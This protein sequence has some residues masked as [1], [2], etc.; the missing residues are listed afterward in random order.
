M[1]RASNPTGSIFLE[2]RANILEALFQLGDSKPE[3]VWE[4]PLS[5]SIIAARINLEAR[6]LK[7]IAAN[8]LKPMLKK[9]ESSKV[10]RIASSGWWKYNSR[11]ARHK[12]RLDSRK[13]QRRTESPS[14]TKRRRVRFSLSFEKLKAT[15]EEIIAAREVDSPKALVKR[16]IA[17]LMILIL[18]LSSLLG[19]KMNLVPPGPRT[20]LRFTRFFR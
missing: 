5:P 14:S 12:P 18:G 7:P 11:K 4:K 13:D 1:I 9:R 17:L 19:S 20:A 8:K 3:F 15:N 6:A 16:S 2:R 10:K